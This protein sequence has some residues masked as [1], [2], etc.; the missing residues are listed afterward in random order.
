MPRSLVKPASRA[1][2][3][4]TADGSSRPIRDQVHR[5]D[6]GERE[7]ILRGRHREHRRRRVMGADGHHRHLADP[8]PRAEL[9]THRPQ[10]LAGLD[11]RRQEAPVHPGGGQDLLGPVMLG[12]R[13]HPGAGGVGDLGATLPREQVSEQVRD[14]QQGRTGREVGCAVVG[15][16]LVERVEGLLG[17]AGELVLPLP[18]ELL[19]EGVGDPVGAVV[20]VGS[21]RPGSRRCRVRGSRSPR[22]HQDPRE[23]IICRVNPHPCSQHVSTQQY[24]LAHWLIP[25]AR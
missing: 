5:G 8:G 9:R 21:P 7:G 16:Q 4:G 24:R 3:E 13:E 23:R 10:A 20:H 1:A 22:E 14:H 25:P 17:D 2:D 6:V 19:G 11:Q 12:H 18:G 15:Q